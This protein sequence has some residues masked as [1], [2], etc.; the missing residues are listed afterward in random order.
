MY[1]CSPSACLQEVILWWEPG[2][3]SPDF[4]SVYPAYSRI[5]FCKCVHV[6]MWVSVCVQRVISDVLLCHHPIPLRQALSCTWSWAS[7]QQT[8]VIFCLC[9]T[10]HEASRCVWPFPVFLCGFLEDSGPH[11]WA[12]SSLSCCF[13]GAFP[14]PG[15]LVLLTVNS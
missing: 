8:P 2:A 10:Q 1:L 5:L 9:C 3:W 12:T 13:W 4:S 6:D 15:I 11:G 7:S 14:V